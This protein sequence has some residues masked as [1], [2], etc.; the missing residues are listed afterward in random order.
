MMMMIPPPAPPPSWPGP[1]V[2]WINEAVAVNRPLPALETSTRLV[3][4]AATTPHWS[5]AINWIVESTVA[6]G[7][8]L[9]CD[10]G[11]CK[12]P[13]SDKA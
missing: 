5:L 6:M 12:N 1:V 10:M 3:L 8:E 11:I 9:S 7:L 13:E 2:G 4:C